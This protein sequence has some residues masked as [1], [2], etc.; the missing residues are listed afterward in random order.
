MN[1]DAAFRRIVSLASAYVKKHPGEAL[2]L[3]GEKPGWLGATT[4]Q[5]ESLED[6]VAEDIATVR[7]HIERCGL[8]IEE[9]EGELAGDEDDGDEPG[10]DE[11][12][13]PE[14]ERARLG[15]DP[16]RDDEDVVADEKPHQCAACAAAKM[17]EPT[18]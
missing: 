15:N 11:A 9:L 16:A 5:R 4:S 14:A 2:A 7:R 12:A 10:Y 8:R 13:V 6:A 1:H 3:V 17:K 18:T